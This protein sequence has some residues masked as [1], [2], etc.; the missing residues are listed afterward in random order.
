VQWAVVLRAR[1]SAMGS[2]TE[3]QA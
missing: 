3:G 1:H 2:G